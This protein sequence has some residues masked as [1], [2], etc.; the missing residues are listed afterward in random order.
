MWN[1]KKEWYKPTYLQNRTRVTD[2]ENKLM[3][4]S[5][6]KEGRINWEIG[7]DIYTL[8]YVK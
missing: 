7:I 1:L 6:E 8:P 3:V 5:G 4:T 2:T